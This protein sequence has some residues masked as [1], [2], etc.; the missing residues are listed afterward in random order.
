MPRPRPLTILIYSGAAA[1]L[2]A[3]ACVVATGSVWL[4]AL[5]TF[6]AGIAELVPCYLDYRQTRRALEEA[7]RSVPDYDVYVPPPRAQAVHWPES[8]GHTIH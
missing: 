7:R 4:V 5:S 8:F 6:L 3:S 1:S 2:A